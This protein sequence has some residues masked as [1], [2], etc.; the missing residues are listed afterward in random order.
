MPP[1]AKSLAPMFRHELPFW[2]YERRV[3]IRDEPFVALMGETA[4]T[5]PWE[6]R[7]RCLHFR[8]WRLS[9]KR[10]RVCTGVEPRVPVHHTGIGRPAIAV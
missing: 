1:L 7:A 9:L 5:P 10:C 6:V 8:L 2:Q 3:V 4:H